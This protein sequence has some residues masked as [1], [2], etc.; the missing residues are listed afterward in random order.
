MCGMIYS[1]FCKTRYST[2]LTLIDTRLLKCKLQVGTTTNQSWQWVNILRAKSQIS[3]KWDSVSS[4]IINFFF[5]LVFFGWLTIQRRW[6]SPRP[7]WD[8]FDQFL[9]LLLAFVDCPCPVMVVILC[10]RRMINWRQTWRIW[11]RSYWKHRNYTTVNT[12]PYSRRCSTTL[13]GLPIIPAL[14]YLCVVFMDIP[15]Y[16]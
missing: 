11:R 15:G 2:V 7:C 14:F 4:V 12:R 3:K 8:R 9:S 1:V 16:L 13:E 6:Q 10:R 5:Y